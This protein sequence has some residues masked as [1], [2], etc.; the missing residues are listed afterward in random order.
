MIHQDPDTIA[1]AHP[2][3]DTEVTAIGG[4][5]VLT[6]EKRLALQGKEIL[7]YLGAALFDS[8]CCGAGGCAY[9]YVPGAIVQE[10]V[11]TSPDGMPISIIL[12]IKDPME[13]EEI[14]IAII[15]RETIAQVNFL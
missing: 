9:A 15:E 13:R 10:G 5:Y 2:L 1:F 8:T 14:K 4:R 11:D 6:H 7:Y 3:L 12:P